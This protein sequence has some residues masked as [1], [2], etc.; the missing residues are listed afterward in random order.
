MTTTLD[1]LDVPQHLAM[2]GVSWSYYEHTLEQIGDRPIRVTFLDGKIEIM[3]P[4]PEHETLKKALARL[5]ENL[6]LEIGWSHKSFGS[7][8]FRREEK[9]AG[10]EPDEC[11]YFH[12]IDAVTG[13]KRFDPIVHPPPDLAI[14]VDILNPSIPREPIYARL[15][16]PEIWRCNGERL[17]VRLLLSDGTYSDSPTSQAFPFLPMVRFATFIKRMIAGDETPVLR[18]FRDWVRTLPIPGGLS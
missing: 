8:T 1:N 4:L 13:M 10:T 12:N 6:T 7:T 3:S 15:G 18:E 5:V 2:T 14:E 17:Q 16:V 11:Y 9:S